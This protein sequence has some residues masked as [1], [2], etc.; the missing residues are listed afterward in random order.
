MKLIYN[1]YFIIQ[2]FERRKVQVLF[3]SSWEG[4]CKQGVKGYHNCDSYD[5]SG[6]A[7]S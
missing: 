4:S 2:S 6:K 7:G 5:G 3:S 1:Y